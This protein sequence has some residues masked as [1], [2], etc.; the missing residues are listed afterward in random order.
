MVDLMMAVHNVIAFI[1]PVCYPGHSRAQPP[2]RA[3]SRLPTR[4]SQRA[5]GVVEWMLRGENIAA[6]FAMFA[7]YYVSHLLR[8]DFLMMFIQRARGFFL[9]FNNT[10]F[11]PD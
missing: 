9:V 2:T 8:S 11:G 7:M 6:M 10:E 4:L 5:A 1:I 3:P